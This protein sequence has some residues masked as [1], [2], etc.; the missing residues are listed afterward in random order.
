MSVRTICAVV[1]A[2]ESVVI[3]LAI[4]VAVIQG[5]IAPGIASGV[6]GTM[7]VAALLLA[8]MQRR[9]GWAYPV[10]WVLQA[11]FLVSSFAV[12][13]LWILAV[14]FLGLWTAGVLLGRKTDAL[15]KAHSQ[16][17]AAE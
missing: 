12:P 8:G 1:L 7:A 10:A 4:P 11:A 2:L 16:A 6:W 3:G 13:L 15:A 9:F 17:T 5:G 14:I